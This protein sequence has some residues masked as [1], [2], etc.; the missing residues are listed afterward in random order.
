MNR[1]RGRALP[2]AVLIASIVRAA[3]NGSPSWRPWAG[4]MTGAKV[5]QQAR[6]RDLAD[7]DHAAGR[8]AERRGLH[9]GEVMRFSNMAGPNSARTA[10]LP[11]S[12]PGAAKIGPGQAVRI[13]AQWLRD[14]HRR[15][16]LGQ[17]GH[18]RCLVPLLARPLPRPRGHR[19]HQRRL[20]Q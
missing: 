12:R 6:V 18:R 10:P 7:A 4:M 13:A 1:P 2:L 20:S 9:V 11:G 19:A 14:Q 5:P 17:R 15:H 8:F 3:G 16:A